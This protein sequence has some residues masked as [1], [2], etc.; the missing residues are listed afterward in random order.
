MST[1][2]AL[3]EDDALEGKM[4]SPGYIIWNNLTSILARTRH[5]AI[6]LALSFVCAV[7]DLSPGAYFLRQDLYPALSKV[8]VERYT[9]HYY[10]LIYFQR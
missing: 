2:E 3:L 4:A 10:Y 9:C 8:R 7:N 5:Q 1:L 6:A